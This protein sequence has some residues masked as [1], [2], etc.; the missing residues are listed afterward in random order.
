[1]LNQPTTI[2]S[3]YS[4]RFGD[5]PIGSQFSQDYAGNPPTSKGKFLAAN[6]SEP[7]RPGYACY[8]IN[9]NDWVL[10]ADDTEAY[11]VT[12]V[13]RYDIQNPTTAINA[14]TTNQRREILYNENNN[15]IFGFRESL[16]IVPTTGVVN[17]G[18]RLG[19]QVTTKTYIPLASLPAQGGAY[20]T[21][22][23]VE[24]IGKGNSAGV[25]AVRQR[26]I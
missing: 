15:L 1:M 2:Q 11:L 4:R 10:P 14:A 8:L 5:K 3:I 9:D 24:V 22:F 23:E 17:V 6:I 12:H 16:V 13:I 20:K 18:D 19:F 21:V 25:V 26:L 7:L